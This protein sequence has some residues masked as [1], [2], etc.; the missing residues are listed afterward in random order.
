MHLDHE[1]GAGLE[2]E[3]PGG[4]GVVAV[5][6]RPETH[7]A[8]V[9][10]ERVRGLF[11]HGDFIEV[12]CNSDLSVCEERDVKGLYAKARAGL[13]KN[14]T[15]I[16]SPYE[17]PEKPAGKKEEQMLEFDEFRK[18]RLL[19]AKVLEAERVDI[20]LFNQDDRDWIYQTTAESTGATRVMAPIGF[21]PG[22][23]LIEWLS[24]LDQA[25]ALT[26][27][28]PLPNATAPG[29]DVIVAPLTSGSG[30]IGAVIVA[31]PL[32]EA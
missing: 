9:D 22:N 31:D 21:M 8:V 13:I 17:A 12:Y 30:G 23:R 7:G 19:V 1:S 3:E 15:G 6:A 10:R 5:E 24:T 16:S 29:E 27:A 26:E 11:P 32:A 20:L 18:V 4:R 28:P 2:A 14:Y 25:Q